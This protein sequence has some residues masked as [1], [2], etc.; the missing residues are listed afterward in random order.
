MNTILRKW[1]QIR[2]GS[3]PI[4]TILGPDPNLSVEYTSS[5]QVSFKKLNISLKIEFHLNT[6]NL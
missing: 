4:K 1:F 6:N 2:V 3:I 5:H